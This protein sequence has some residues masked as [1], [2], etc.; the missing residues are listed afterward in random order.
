MTDYHP[1][2]IAGAVSIALENISVVVVTRMRQ[3]GKT[4]FLCSQSD[5]SDRSYVSFDD[6]APFESAKSDPDQFYSR[7]VNDP[8]V[9]FEF[10]VRP[11]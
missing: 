10:K 9:L 2:D 11:L 3:M 7:F 5:L 6:F 4:T 1:R 8:H